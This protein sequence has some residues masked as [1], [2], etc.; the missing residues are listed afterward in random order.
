MTRAAVTGQASP[1]KAAPYNTLGQQFTADNV[2]ASAALAEAESFKQEFGG[3]LIQ[4][5]TKLG[6]AREID[7]VRSAATF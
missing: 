5:A 2:L 6:L 4:A 3:G 7:L 1:L